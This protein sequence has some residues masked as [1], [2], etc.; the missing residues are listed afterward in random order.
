MHTLF[1]VCLLS[2]LAAISARNLLSEQDLAS[3]YDAGAARAPR[4][5][6]PRLLKIPKPTQRY[7]QPAPA[8]KVAVGNLH[9]S[10]VARSSIF[11]YLPR[12]PARAP[13]GA[14]GY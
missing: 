1:G 13:L 3:A 7:S 5:V 2:P 11:A 9:D 14:T 10:C 8:C 6:Y 12:R 4:D